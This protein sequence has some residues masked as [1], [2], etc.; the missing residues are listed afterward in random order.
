M[1]EIK[2]PN[3]G[4]VFQVDES[5]F[6]DIVRQVRDEEFNREVRER[7]SLLEEKL[8]AKLAAGETEK[9]LAVAEAIAEAEKKLAQKDAEIAEKSSQIEKMRADAKAEDVKR[10]LEITEAVNSIEKERDDLA[11][12][13]RAQETERKLIETSLKERYEEKLRLKEDEI[14]YYKDFKARQSTKMVGESLE[15]HCENEFNKLRAIGFQDAYFEKDN[16]ARTGSKGDYIYR[17][18]D[19]NGNETISIMFEMKNENDETATKKKNEDFLKELHKDRTEKNCEYAILV[20]LLEPDSELYNS[21]IVDKSHRYPK[22]YVV[23]PQFFIPIITIL[24]NAA[25]NAMEYKAELASVRSQNIDIKIGRA[26][27]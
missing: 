6:A 15:Q 23:R 2:C 17:E 9:K 18:T 7:E 10:R 14:A 22:M 24:R 3:C 16:D 13:L 27:V 20:S 26:H 21:G 5:G 25:L 19:E 8:T 1:Q 4:T 11:A 12:K